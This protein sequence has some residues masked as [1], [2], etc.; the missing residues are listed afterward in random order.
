MNKLSSSKIFSL[1]NIGSLT[2]LLVLLLISVSPVNAELIKHRFD[3]ELY[4]YDELDPFTTNFVTSASIEIG[5][6]TEFAEESID[7]DYL[8]ED[9]AFEY[10]NFSGINVAGA[11]ENYSFDF[12]DFADSIAFFSAKAYS[13]SFSGDGFDNGFYEIVMDIDLSAFLPGVFGNVSFEL[14]NDAFEQIGFVDAIDDNFDTVFSGEIVIN[15][16]AVSVNAPGI[17]MLFGLSLFVLLARKSR[18]IL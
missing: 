5:A 14:Y 6:L 1:A 11:Q 8:W 2:S 17:A 10:I 9:D 13:F 18:H 4:Q 16:S 12:T 15:S 7:G 3:V